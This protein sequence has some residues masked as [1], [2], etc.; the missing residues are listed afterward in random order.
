MDNTEAL[1]HYALIGIV[2]GLLT[3]AVIIGFRVLIEWPAQF[4][5]PG[6]DSEN[7]EQLPT[8]AHFALP[9]GGAILLG[10][11][12]RLTGNDNQRTGLIHVIDRLH[13]HH[14]DL[15]VR[16]A[17]VQFFGGAFAIACGQSA[18]REGPAVHLGSAVTSRLAS[19]LKLPNNSTRVLIGCGTAAAIA[20]SFNT[21]IAGVIFAMEVVLLEYTV[22]GFTPIILAAVSGTL[23]THFTFGTAPAFAVP[24]IQ[25]ASITELPIMLGLGLAAGAVGAVFIVI[26]KTF[27]RFG[28]QPVMLRMAIAGA[29]T[30][31]CALLVPAVM[32]LGYDSIYGIMTGEV[33]LPAL[34]AL[35]AAKVLATA[36]SCGMGM[37]IGFIGPNLVIGACLGGC[38]GI[39]AQYLLPGEASNIAFYTLLGMGASMA[40]LLNAPMAAIMA[41]TELTHS[42]QIILPT[43]LTVVAATLVNTDVFRQKSIVHAILKMSGKTAEL[44]PLASILQRTAVTEVMSQSLALSSRR[45]SLEGMKRLAISSAKW[46]VFVEEDQ[47]HAIRTE[48]LGAID[49]DN[50]EA[51]ADIDA[52]SL[53]VSKHTL[54]RIG[55]RATLYEAL[56]TMESY[57]RDILAI[58]SHRHGEIIGI[59]THAQIEQHYRKL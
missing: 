56:S 40:A 45:V 11:M 2:S 48:K 34:L 9:F 22:A 3:G 32:G 1:F 59:I 10:L 57:N 12:L 31:L 58:E 44:S 27:S 49:F 6:G 17:L 42:A 50:M 19:A 13:H 8:W 33:L 43:M 37:P 18:G 53:K 16:N 30:G 15:P 41:V 23:I 26:Q 14:G 51:D 24:N 39:L 4:W 52:L 36:V 5:L 38:F 35:L 21:P 55:S 7:F 29:V 25:L 47:D 20:A 54:M 46:L 28:E